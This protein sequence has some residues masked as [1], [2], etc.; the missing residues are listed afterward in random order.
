MRL[1]IGIPLA[2]EV[3]KELAA[4]SARL[5]SPGDGLRWSRPEGWHITLQFLGQTS[6]EQYVCV[7]AALRTI[8]HAPFEIQLDAPGFFDRSGVFFVGA[9]LSPEL[10]RLQELVVAATRRCG[11]VPEDRP[12]HPHITL[13]RD[14]E[15]HKGLR[16]LKS[17]VSQDVHFSRFLAGEFLLYQSF[18]GPGGSRYEVR[19][20]FALAAPTESPAGL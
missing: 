2:A 19:E 10:C 20:R 12:Y 4:L 11:F 5:Q 15:G 16:M 1:F 3:V 17:R 13:A 14:K 9:G 18:P 7:A 6:A 8:R